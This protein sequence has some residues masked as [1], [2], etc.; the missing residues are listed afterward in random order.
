MYRSTWDSPGMSL[1]R[2]TDR[3]DPKVTARAGAILGLM[4]GLGLF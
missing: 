1:V 3:M 4:L 2:V